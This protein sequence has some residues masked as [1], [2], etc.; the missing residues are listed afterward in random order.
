MNHDRVKSFCETLI[1]ENIQIKYTFP[2]ALRGDIL[3]KHEISLLKQSGMYFCS[4]ALESGSPRIQKMTQKNINIERLL[5]NIEY[6]SSLKVFTNGFV[7]LGF[8][9]E[10]QEEIEQTI[11]V[12]CKSSLH[13]ISFFTLT[14]FPNTKIYNYIKEHQPDRLGKISYNDIDFSNIKCNFSTVPDDLFFKYQKEANF[15]FYI[16]IQRI[17]RLIRYYPKPFSLFQCLP[18]FI[19]RLLKSI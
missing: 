6:A 18:I 7:I 8:P 3:T 15:K 1:N 19:K 10:T 16:N 12:A 17:Y 13:S 5:E 9:T 2:N 4:F 14:P 11:E